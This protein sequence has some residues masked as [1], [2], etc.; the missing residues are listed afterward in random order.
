[1]LRVGNTIYLGGTF[2]DLQDPNSTATVGVTNLA[3]I[4]ATTGLPTSF[5]PAVN[6]EVFGAGPIVPTDLVCTQWAT[7]PPSDGATQKRIAV[8]D[9]T[10]GALMAWKPYAWPNNVVRAIAV[11]SDHVYIGG[12]F[13][14]LGTT[15]AAHIAALSPVDGAAVAGLHGVCRRSG[16]GLCSHVEPPLHRGQLHQRQRH[17]QGKLTAINPTTGATIAGVYHPTYP[18]LDL[19]AGTRLYAAGGGGGG[20]ALAVN[21]ATGAK[22]WEKKTDGNVQAVDVLNDT[23]YFGGHFL[24]YDGT[25]VAQLVRADPATGALDTTW[26]P[27][28]TAGFLGVF[29]IDGYGPNKLY[30]GGD[31]TRV[32]GRQTHQLRR[33]SPMARRRPTADVSVSRSPAAPA[34][35]TLGQNVTYTARP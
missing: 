7:S 32:G 13:T 2:S 10:T 6:G 25:V 8:F 9:T 18:V 35:P 34:S 17:P 4:D 33:S 29:A 27:Q 20:K 5:A 23:P 12:A 21:L 22:I 1:M 3:G 14:T 16:A 19:A 28:V 15:P 26:L 24:K 30:V 31:F 11:T